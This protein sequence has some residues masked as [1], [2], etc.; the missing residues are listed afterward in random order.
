MKQETKATLQ[1]VATSIFFTCVL[2][3]IFSSALYLYNGKILFNILLSLGCVLGIGYLY[4]LFIIQR[5]NK[6]LVLQQVE[7]EKEKQRIMFNVE[8]CECSKVHEVQMDFTSD[9]IFTCDD[10]ETTNKVFYV[11]K[12]G[13]TT[14]IPE[15]TSVVKLIDE[16]VK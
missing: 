3:L 6:F 13:R 10:C 8:C 9:I 11:M 2:V 1:L 16:F 7:I 14:D 12:T 4:N 5:F 15:D